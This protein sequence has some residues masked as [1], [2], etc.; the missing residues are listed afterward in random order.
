MLKFWL[1]LSLLITLPVVTC[2]ASDEETAADKDFWYLI[3]QSDL[4]YIDTN[5]GQVV[6]ALTDSVAPEHVKRFKTLVSEGFYNQQ[7][8]Y[9]VIEGFVAQAGAN[10]QQ[11]EGEAYPPLP[12]EFSKSSVEGFFEVERPAPFA[13]VAGFINGFAAGTTPDRQGYWLTHC[14]GAVAMARDNKADTATTDFYIVLGQAPRHLDRNMSVF[15][16][17]VAGMAAL[18][19]LPRGEK[20]NGGVISRPGEASA[21]VGAALGT[22]LPADQQRRFRIQLPGHSAYQNRLLTTKTLSNSFFVDKSL[23]P[24]AID[25]CYVQTLV[26]EI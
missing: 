26:E 10:A 13:P 21:I 12:A 24:R 22:S 8:F 3:P 11:P 1:L 25:I 2:A 23:A 7:H 4:V 16:R 5:Q 20:D 6:V 17:V 19:R 14:P 18:Q 9:R 15:G